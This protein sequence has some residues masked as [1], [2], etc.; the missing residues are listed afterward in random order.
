MWYLLI[1][2]IFSYA[3][4]E[5]FYRVTEIG[6]YGSDVFFYYETAK[7]YL[8]GDFIATEHFRPLAYS[9]YA[10]AMKVGGVN[11]YSIKI[12]NSILDLLNILVILLLSVK[13]LRNRWWALVPTFLYVML[14]EPALQSRTELLHV[15][16]T[17]PLLICCLLMTYA[18]DYWKEQ[19]SYYFLFAAGV[20]LGLSTNLHPSLNLLGPLFALTIF[21]FIFYR[22]NN[23]CEL[24]SAVGRTALFTAGFI[25]VYI[26]TFSLIGFQNGWQ[27]FTG[28]RSSQ[29]GGSLSLFENLLWS[30]QSFVN[31]NSSIV[32]ASLIYLL[33]IAWLWKR[34]PQRHHFFYTMTFILCIGYAVLY[35][36][37]VPKFQLIRTFLPLMPLLLITSTAAFKDVVPEKKWKIWAGL[38]LLVFCTWSLRPERRFWPISAYDPVTITHAVY[39][40]MQSQL[41]PEDQ[42]LIL[43]LI[44][45]GDRKPFSQPAYFGSNAQYVIESPANNTK[46]LLNPTSR[47]WIILLK[48]GLDPSIPIDFQRSRKEF[49]K[50]LT[51][52]L[53]MAPEQYDAKLENHLWRK[54]ILLSGYQ[55]FVETERFEIF[56]RSE[57]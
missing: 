20:G 5:R 36:V 40:N 14:T 16:S 17:L 49:E 44:A 19:R 28:N 4:F 42:F 32:M 21:V 41:Q 25:A 55:P 50:Q 35:A 39:K 38:A 26:F 30:F 24:K 56:K 18:F 2:V 11:F 48:D 52:Y 23:S 10:L 54:Q 51:K 29:S 6:L 33:L 57:K 46:E 43:P 13:L 8:T 53:N 9:L 45:Y 3:A 7:K 27:A 22:T 1:L 47:K 12:F 15:P 34:G 31:G 37:L